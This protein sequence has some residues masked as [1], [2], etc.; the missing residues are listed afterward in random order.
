VLVSLSRRLDQIVR[1][2][3]RP[4]RPSNVTAPAPTRARIPT[5]VTTEPLEQRVLLSS[6]YVS[7]SGSDSNTGSLSAPFRTIQRAA[8]LAGPGDTVFIRAGTYR[9]TVRPARSGGSGSP[10]VFRPYNSETVTVSGADVITGWSGHSGRIYRA[11]QPWDLG[12]GEN[13]VFVDGRMMIEARWP[14]TTLDVTHPRLASADSIGVTMNG[15]KSRSDLRDSALT[16]PDGAWDGAT[17]HIAP[18]HAWVAQTSTI[19]DHTRG[20]LVYTYQQ[21]NERHEKPEAG[22]QYYLTGKFHA[23]DSAGE[24]FRQ[25]DGSLFLWTPAGDSPASHRVEAKRRDFAFDLRGR[26]NVRIDGLNIFAA[27]ITTDSSSDAITLAGIDARYVSH[28]TLMSTG[29]SRPD[30]TGI[31]LFGTDSVIR[32]SVIAFSSGHGIAIAG[33][34][35]RVENVVVHDVGYNAG[36]EAGINVRGDDHVVTRNTIYNAGRSGIKIGYARN[37]KL[38]YNLIHDVM[39]QATDGGGIYTYGTDAENTEIAYNVIYNSRSEGFGAVGVY[40][41]NYSSKYVV[42][43]NVV[44]NSDHA[45]KMNPTSRNNLV[46]NNTFV[47]VDYSIAT[48]KSGDMLGS[49][50][51]NNIFTKTA[52]IDP[53]SVKQNNI[54]PGTDPG[55]VNLSKYD[56]RLRTGSK[57]IDA[58]MNVGAITNGYTGKAPDIGAYE[59]GKSAWRAGA[60]ISSPVRPGPAPAPAPA[61]APKPPP[62]ASPGA[63]DPRN[64]IQAENYVAQSGVR[65]GIT[66]IGHLESGD[67]ASYGP[68]D[69]GSGALRTFTAKLAVEDGWQGKRIELRLGSP[70]GRLVGSLTTKATGSW[71]HQEEQSTTLFEKV[72]GVHMLYLVFQGGAGVA[73][74]DSFLFS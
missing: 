57:A 46:Y 41:D 32:D 35:N 20:R 51:R 3:V 59:Y 19:S 25:S 67:W 73:T 72:T 36:N 49:I 71:T 54:N 5:R 43:H 58:G 7:T 74:L 66:I 42:H 37:L 4:V 52:S 45:M 21:M 8:N 39:Q 12:F 30:T 70:T 33:S 48:S 16:H 68:L 34:R 9:E 22:D 31:N 61:P 1:R 62:A 26:S 50:F 60:S 53:R 55:F 64:R 38:T 28:Y 24:W 18:G 65:K 11:R 23:L 40:L 56:L 14:N 63:K 17:I 10:V 13:Q 27:T 69:F 2:F 15:D 6:F 29:W 47:G 44:W